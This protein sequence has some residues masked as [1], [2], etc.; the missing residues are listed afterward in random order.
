VDEDNMNW[1]G[2]VRFSL[3]GRLTALSPDDILTGQIKR[4]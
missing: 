3:G 2:N 4:L 1:T